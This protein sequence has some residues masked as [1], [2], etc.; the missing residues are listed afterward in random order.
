MLGRLYAVFPV[1][2]HCMSRALSP[3]LAK[4]YLFCLFSCCFI[5]K[6]FSLGSEVGRVFAFCCYLFW[7]RGSGCL[8]Q[9]TV[10]KRV[11]LAR[12]KLPR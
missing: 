6:C 10:G 12:L 7:D 1:L 5:F 9:E 8:R 2:G 3:E 11:G 4:Q